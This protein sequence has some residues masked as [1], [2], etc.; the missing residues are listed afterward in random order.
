MPRENEP[1]DIRNYMP[2]AVDTPLSY[3]TPDRRI[4][5][6]T[7]IRSTLDRNLKIIE[8]MLEEEG[9]LTQL[10]MV[11]IRLKI[12]KGLYKNGTNR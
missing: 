9:L 2:E 4:Q 10:N 5:Q 12:M 7:P 8:L 1:I 11:R 3:G 6:P